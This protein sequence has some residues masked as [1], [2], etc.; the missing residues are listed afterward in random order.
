MDHILRFLR[1]F[2]SDWEKFVR[3]VF[4]PFVGPADVNYL[5][6]TQNIDVSHLPPA[7]IAQIRKK[8]DTARM[9]TVVV[10]ES[11]MSTETLIVSED[12][13]DYVNFGAV[14]RN[15]LGQQAQYASKYLAPTSVRHSLGFG[16]RLRHAEDLGD[17]HKIQIHKEDVDTFVERV[18]TFRVLVGNMSQENADVYRVRGL[19]G[20]CFTDGSKVRLGQSLKDFG[21][22]HP[23]TLVEV[24]KLAVGE[25]NP[26]KVGPVIRLRDDPT[27]FATE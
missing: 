11:K 23:A 20:K 6:K 4:A 25:F 13:R 2:S 1:P 3:N 10:F 18:L 27:R 19:N 15:L 12:P 17:Y 16:L 26:D 5:L 14:C 21:I 9:D 8:F 22:T 24:A 7:T